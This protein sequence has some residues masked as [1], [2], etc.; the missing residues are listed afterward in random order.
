MVTIRTALRATEVENISG[1]DVS[2][3]SSS[4]TLIKGLDWI[5]K[6]I[7]D[8]INALLAVSD[9]STIMGKSVCLIIS[10]QQAK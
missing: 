2:I 4:Q 7:M 1:M 5:E 6:L 8:S 10:K 3:F 9:T